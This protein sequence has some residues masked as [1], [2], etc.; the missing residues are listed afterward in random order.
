MKLRRLLLFAAVSLIASLAFPAATTDDDLAKTTLTKVG[1]L[2]PA[3]VGT[4]ITG[5]SFA[6]EQ[7]KGKVVVLSLFA[8]W[9]G[10]CNAELPH[11]EK[12]LWQAFRGRGLVVLAVAREEG[13]DKLRPFA[14]K[15]GLTFPLLPDPERKIFN[16]FATNYIP[17][18]YV[19]G[20]DGRIK[21]QS[22]GFDEVEFRTA[23]A[24]V[25]QELEGGAPSPPKT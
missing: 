10:P 25:R 23:V 1:N 19:I 7:L 20:A 12:E 2:A 14:A 24:V 5:E 16:L 17:R 22:V 15:L 6:L 18:L 11:V 3:F 13:P 9:C 21:F 8:T 4:A